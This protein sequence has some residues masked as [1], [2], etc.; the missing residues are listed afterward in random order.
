MSAA[1][2]LGMTA[3]WLA[4]IGQCRLKAPTVGALINLG[5]SAL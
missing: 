4:Q 2:A 5:R 1:N 3:S